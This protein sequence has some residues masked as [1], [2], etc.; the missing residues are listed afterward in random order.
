VRTRQVSARS[1][2]HGGARKLDLLLSVGADPNQR[3]TGKADWPPL[4]VAIRN[5]DAQSASVLLAHGADPNARWCSPV[6][7]PFD[8]KPQSTPSGCDSAH[9]RTALMWAALS[10]DVDMIEVLLESGGDK[11]LRDWEN[12]TA[13]DHAVLSNRRDVVAALDEPKR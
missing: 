3:V 6:V 5:R 13:R 12:R 7:Y 2:L 1:P 8:T 11:T 4:A 10:D 9:G